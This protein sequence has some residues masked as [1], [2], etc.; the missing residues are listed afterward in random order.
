MTPQTQDRA[1]HD[2]QWA[3]DPTDCRLLKVA[4]GLEGACLV[5]LDEHSLPHLECPLLPLVVPWFCGPCTQ[6]LT[7]TAA[8]VGLRVDRIA[9]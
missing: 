8:M 4:F 3:Y 6:P 1:T 2:G 7:W 5:I 9:E